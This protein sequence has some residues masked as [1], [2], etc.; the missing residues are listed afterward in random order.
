MTFYDCKIHLYPQEWVYVC[1][2]IISRKELAIFFVKLSS[3]LTEAEYWIGQT[4]KLILS[5]HQYI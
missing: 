5:T 2:H 4:V 3:W 1:Q